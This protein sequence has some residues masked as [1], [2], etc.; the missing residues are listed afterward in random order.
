MARHPVIAGFLILFALLGAAELGLRV[1]TSWDSRWNIR[2]GA[3][4]RFDPV[5]AFR[6]KSDFDL[7][8]GFRTNEYGYLAP[9]N[10]QHGLPPTEL[11][12]LYLGDSVTFTPVPGNYPSQVEALLE[13]DGTPIQTVNAAVPGFAT[14][15]ALALLETELVEFDADVFFVYLG[16]NDLGQFGPEGL[17]YKREQAGYEI[18]GAQ[19]L[20]SNIYLPRL[21][22]ALQRHRRSSE[23]AVN[24]PLQGEEL[25]LY[26]E[27]E[28]T[29]FDE[30]LR[31]ILRIAKER[32]PR[33]Y[34]MNLATITS[35]DPS[36]SELERAHFPTGMSKNLR[37]LHRLVLQYNEIVERVAREEGVPMI[38]FFG[39]FDT[40]EARLDFNDSNHVNPAGGVRMA[41]AIIDVIEDVD[42]ASRVTRA[43]R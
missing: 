43:A 8:D 1:L 4:K 24:E 32:W 37:K 30:N 22:F 31:K 17:P 42:L 9:Q 2:L 21:V 23:P 26:D 38:D 27:Y 13:A 5:T 20:F 15:N 35:D 29:H 16:H 14:H 18:T 28:A 19:R 34:V 11:R 3:N 25:R 6:L 33:V 40:R 7:G 41:R 10:L 36:Q 39:L 12:L